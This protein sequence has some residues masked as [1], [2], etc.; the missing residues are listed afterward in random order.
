L[1]NILLHA[2]NGILI[3][4]IF[5]KLFKK[6]LTAFIPA[7]IFSLHPVNTEAVTYISGTADPLSLFFSLLAIWFYLKHTKNYYVVSL[8]CGILAL[9]SKESMVILPLLIILVDLYRKK[10]RENFYKYIPFFLIVGVYT[11]LRLTILNFTGSINLYNEENVYTSNL[12]YRIFTFLAALNEYYK[13][14]FFPIDLRYDRA[15]P[16]FTS[17][18]Q[19]QVLISFFTIVILTYLSYRFFENQRIVFFSIFWFFTSLLPYSG[20]IP[21]NALIMEHWLYVPMIGVWA[22]ISYFLT[23]LDKKI[24]IIILIPLLLSFSFLTFNRNKDWKD[25]ITFYTK[26]L[27]H[28]PYIAR[29]RNNLAMAYEEKGMLIEAEREY[30][31]AIELDDRYPQTHY[32]LALLYLKENRIEEGIEEL[33]RAIEIDDNFIYAHQKLAEVYLKLGRYEEAR[34]EMIKV[35]RLMK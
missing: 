30:K 11:T 10:F 16:V 29:V 4:L 3:Y 2:A 17:L 32:N 26:I 28:N 33:K 22:G 23:K 21:I 7:I 27:S 5:K 13:L 25:P 9:L 24:V 6:R 14:L 12:H 31:K 19:K 35:E 8:I 34:R 15:F 20:I 1:L 18:F